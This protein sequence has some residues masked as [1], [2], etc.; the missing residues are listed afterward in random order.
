MNDVLTLLK[1]YI[2]QNIKTWMRF[3]HNVLKLLYLY[4]LD[5]MEY[6][7][8]SSTFI[9]P[10]KNK[11]MLE[12]RIVA[13]YH[14]IEKGLSFKNTKTGFGKLIVRDLLQLLEI[15]KQQ[16]NSKD[17]LVYDCAVSALIKYIEFNER[18]YQDMENIKLKVSKLQNGQKSGG[19]I[20]VQKQDILRNATMDFMRF[21]RSRHSIRHFSNEPV[22]INKVLQAI[23]LA[24]TAP[25]VCNRQASRVYVITQKTQVD[26]ILDIQGGN[27]GFGTL[28]DNVIVITST[29]HA[30]D[31]TQERNQAFIDG[32]IYAMNLLY[33]LHSVGLGTCPL[34]WC[35]TP[36]STKKVKRYI[37]IPSHERIIMLIGVG[38]IPNKFEI[39]ESKRCSVESVYKIVKDIREL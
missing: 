30:F 33:A 11:E 31:G 34:V 8:Y 22:D 37:N 21:S 38:N 24:Q 19:T 7:R 35:A 36:A 4:F 10:T 14:I 29:L 15:Y 18:R 23:K 12:A 25:S 32:G 26:N 20:T 9:S 16:Y 39:A 17:S 13:H 2:P 3:I 5:M 6:A 1:K 28:I 27:R